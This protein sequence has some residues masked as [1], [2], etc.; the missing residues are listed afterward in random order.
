MRAEEDGQRHPGDGGGDQREDRDAEPV[1]VV[2][3]GDGDRRGQR[4]TAD[5]GRH[6]PP[7][8]RHAGAQHAPLQRPDDGPDGRPPHE[9]LDHVGHQ[10]AALGFGG[11][12]QPDPDAEPDTGRQRPSTGIAEEA[13]KDALLER[14]DHAADA[15]H[16]HWEQHVARLPDHRVHGDE[17]A[18]GDHDADGRGHDP[19][20]P[21]RPG[22][23][24][25]LR[26]FA[27]RFLLRVLTTDA[28][29]QA[30]RRSSGVKAQFG[31]ALAGR[32]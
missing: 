4:P 31:N 5:A 25:G 1:D 23:G 30:A 11:D 20:N 7:R 27:H 10:R 26:W 14:P 21:Q 17:P 18:G 9:A 16:Q 24:A 29:N 13:P 28:P 8:P 19:T 3:G 22:S 6:P 32:R 2:V 15:G 12:S